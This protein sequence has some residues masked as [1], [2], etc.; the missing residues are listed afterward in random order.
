MI[1]RLPEWSL[2][3]ILQRSCNDGTVE[4][5]YGCAAKVYGKDDKLLGE[6]DLVIDSMGLYSSLRHNRVIDSDKDGNIIN[7]SGGKA[8]LHFKGEM[9]VHG[10]IDDPKW[11]EEG[12]KF[13]GRHG[14]I[15][16][17]SKGLFMLFQRYGAGAKD[18]RTAFFFMVKT[19]D[20]DPEGLF[21]EIG[22]PVAKSRKEGRITRSSP[23]YETLMKYMK[24]YTSDY[25][26]IFHEMMDNIDA[27]SIRP[28][29]FHAENVRMRTPSD[30]GTVAC[31]PLICLGDSLRNCGLGGGGILA[32]RD[33]IEFANEVQKPEMFHPETGQVNLKLLRGLEENMLERKKEFYLERTTT[34][35]VS[36]RPK[37]G[38]DRTLRVSELMPDEWP[39][40]K[41]K[42]VAFFLG[43]IFKLSNVWY[44]FDAATGPGVGS[45]TDSPVYPRVKKALE[46][47]ALRK[48][49]Q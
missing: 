5:E 34:K 2:L 36:A 29:Y 16:V 44:K 20:N 19:E 11:G 37:P 7:H 18:P 48:S 43:G 23:H 13:L 33:V 49:D 8:K 1:L 17:G 14:S 26:P 24:D 41:R 12:D 28:N 22:I 35:I 39:V 31:L 15:G 45:S 47:R 21:R 42:I 32:M 30:P 10:T 3:C 4:P 46:E 9:F 27:L 40:Y 25:H 6:Y 38:E